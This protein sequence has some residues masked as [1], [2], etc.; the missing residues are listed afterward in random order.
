MQSE[1]LVIGIYG[2]SGSGKTTL[3]K[4]LAVRLRERG[5]WTGVLAQDAFL[6]ADKVTQH[7][8]FRANWELVEVVDFEGFLRAIG[9][10]KAWAS[11]GA[12]APLVVGTRRGD[13]VYEGEREAD[14]AG[15]RRR[16]LVLE[17]FK[18]FSD[19]RVADLC[20]V[21]FVLDA[22]ASVCCGRRYG[23]SRRG[24]KVTEEYSA[25]YHGLVWEHH[26]RYHDAAL[27]YCAGRPHHILDA[28]Q[29]MDTLVRD[30]SSIVAEQLL[31]SL[32]D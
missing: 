6:D 13:V 25:W 5:C 18:L 4:R 10:W 19:R 31:V 14:P 26:L 32:S 16:V 3:A 24:A 30:A 29:P 1:P 21:R 12:A 23:R 28:T 9:E 20:H 7:P 2:P 8:V 27:K 15:T 11:K 17:G 22:P